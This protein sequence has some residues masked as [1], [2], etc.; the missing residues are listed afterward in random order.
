MKKKVQVIILAAGK[1]SRMRQDKP[2]ALVELE[3]KPMVQHLLDSVRESGVDDEPIIVVGY[4]AGNVKEILGPDYTY[5]MQTEQLGTGHA[6]LSA[7]EAAEG[8]AEM[9]LVL[10]ADTPLIS[11]ESIKQIVET[12]EKEGGAMT[13]ATVT[14]PDYEG[15][16]KNLYDYGRI[17]RGPD[18]NVIRSVERK[19]AEKLNDQETLAIKEVNPSFNCYNDD[20]LWDALLEI[21]PSSA[22]AEYYLTDLIQI[23][24]ERGERIN[25]ISIEAHEALGINS[26]EQRQ[27][28]EELLR[29]RRISRQE[30]KTRVV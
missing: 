27:I 14:V 17:V 3:G 2:K 23:A 8:K 25:T 6:V 22:Q 12:Q 9:V 4:Q 16:R 26:P 15:Y 29:E 1:G 21:R 30:E 28:A 19:E 10:Y 13:F 11:G 24:I 7:R 20:F 5:V 18:G